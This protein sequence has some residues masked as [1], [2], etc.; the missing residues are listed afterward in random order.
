MRQAK[1]EHEK[2]E[3]CLSAER[4]REGRE[5]MILLL[6]INDRSTFV[7]FTQIFLMFN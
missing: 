7:S 2:Q 4:A 1:N 3:K 6:T 5:R